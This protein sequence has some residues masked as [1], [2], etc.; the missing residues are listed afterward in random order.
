MNKL[1]FFLTILLVGTGLWWWTQRAQPKPEV[2][3][4]VQVTPDEWRQRLNPMQHK[5]LREHG[6][7][8][9]F[10]GAYHDH[11]KKGHYRCAGCDH[12]LFSSSQKYDSGTGWPSTGPP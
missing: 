3:F 12:P 2:S 11:K 8:R 10:A 5:M 7:E 9:A 1:F 6:T 4:E